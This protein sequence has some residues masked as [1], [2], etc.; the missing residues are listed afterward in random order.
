MASGNQAGFSLDARI[1][2]DSRPVLTLGLCELRAQDD[3][4]AVAAGLRSGALSVRISESRPRGGVNGM[5]DVGEGGRL[6]R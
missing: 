2:G 5:P 3:A 4:L 6:A 1:A